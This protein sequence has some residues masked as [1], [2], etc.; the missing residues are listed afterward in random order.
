[1]AARKAVFKVELMG[2]TS[3]SELYLASHK[4]WFIKYRISY[5]ARS[6]PF[7]RPEVAKFVDS[8]RLIPQN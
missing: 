2:E 1:M 5:P 8:L 7:A 6:A 4:G 3:E